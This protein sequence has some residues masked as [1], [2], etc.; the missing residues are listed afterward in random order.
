VCI[1][2]CF[3]VSS[4]D[5]FYF[6]FNCFECVRVSSGGGMSSTSCHVQVFDACFRLAYM[7]W[8]AWWANITTA[9]LES[10]EVVFWYGGRVMLIGCCW[11]HGLLGGTFNLSDLSLHLFPLG[12]RRIL[13]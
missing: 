4:I 7:A 8:L 13:P 1:G 2:R 10:R 5:E 11:V 6:L 3:D 12:E 9:V